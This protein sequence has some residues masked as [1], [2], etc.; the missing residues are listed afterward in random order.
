MGVIV[1]IG[2]AAIIMALDFGV[3]QAHMTRML[4]EHGIEIPQGVV[5]PPVYGFLAAVSAG[6]TEETVF[7]LFGV[8]LLVWLGRRMFQRGEGPPHQVVLWVAGFLV[9]VLFAAAH[10]FNAKAMGLPIN[11]LILSRT[12][13]LNGLAGVAFGWLFWTYGLESAMLAHFFTDVGLYVLLP[14]VILQE[15]PMATTVAGVFVA[16]LVVFVIA[17]AGRTI[18]GEREAL[19][20]E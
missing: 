1:G 20:S 2:C 18:A 17:W 13:V 12:L 8:S 11:G 5:A 14:I 19:G 4:M 3:F 15:T 6:I 7:R 10:L 16:A 9:A